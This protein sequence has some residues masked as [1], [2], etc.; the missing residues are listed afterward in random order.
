MAITNG[1]N[2]QDTLYFRDKHIP[3]IV[4]IAEIAPTQIA[5]R[6]WFVTSDTNTYFIDS[7]TIDYIV[8]HSGEVYEF[9][10]DDNEVGNDFYT[11]TRTALKFKLISPI[12]HHV[13]FSYEVLVK[14]KESLEFGLII[15]GITNEYGYKV[16]GAVLRCGYKFISTPLTTKYR[17]Q[18]HGEYFKPE[19][20]IGS[21]GRIS[22]ATEPIMGS[23][24][25]TF[26]AIMTSF[27]YQWIVL[28]K[29]VIDWGGGIGYVVSSNYHSTSMQNSNYNYHYAFLS[30]DDDF[31]L[32]INVNFKIGLILGKPKH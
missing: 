10:S 21:Y 11:K 2:A 32:A 15:P 29:I 12:L 16:R 1:V 9:P 5:Y 22:R 17:H 20:I 6:M 3:K 31:P 14:D 8:M 24:K 23:H 7:K 18:L 30:W 4:A 28:D 19:L 25:Y 27:G 26:A 13:S